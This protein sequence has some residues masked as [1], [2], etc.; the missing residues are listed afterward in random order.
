MDEKKVRMNDDAEAAR[1][2]II[3]IKK[4]MVE[5]QKEINESEKKLKSNRNS[6]RTHKAMKLYGDI[7][8]ILGF[9]EK[10]RLCYTEKDFDRLAVSIKTRIKELI[11]METQLNGHLEPALIQ[12]Q[13][14]LFKP[15]SD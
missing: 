1:R 14:E 11:R 13:Q 12:P 6:I 7:I 5:L 15:S 8:S 9:Q 2:N 3:E 4:R 10:E